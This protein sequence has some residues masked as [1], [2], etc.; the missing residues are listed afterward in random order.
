L[1]LIFILFSKYVFAQ[2]QPYSNLRK[3]FISTKEK[4]LIVDT[5]SI[6]PN[7][8]FITGVSPDK[9]HLD[10]VN[11]S[12]LWKERPLPDSVLITYRTFPYKLNSV[13]K[14][15]NYD[16]IRFNFDKE[17][18]VFNPNK[19]QSTKVFDF[20]DINYNGSFGRGISFGN[21]QDAVVNSSLNLQLNGFIGDS[22]ELSAAISDNTLPIQPEGNTQDIRDFDRIYMQIK[23]RGWQANFGDIDIRQSSNYFLNFYKRLQGASFQTD[24]RV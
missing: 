15:F 11:A 24:N 1:I 4:Q 5:L 19:S 2:I 7:T 18:F 6:V 13:T 8:F 23:K 3:K 9:Y 10:L 22:L 14:R 21:N 12:I 16:S 17:P 20:G